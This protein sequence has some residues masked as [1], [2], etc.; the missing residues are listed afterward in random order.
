MVRFAPDSGH[1]QVSDTKGAITVSSRIAVK[2]SVT[3]P[4]TFVAI[5]VTYRS[6]R[7]PKGAFRKADLNAERVR[8]L[9]A[10][11]H[12]AP[13]RLRASTRPA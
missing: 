6:S 8:R 1:S 3:S 7:S 5:I 10:D 12:S 2:K 13:G 4:L 9:R 11:L